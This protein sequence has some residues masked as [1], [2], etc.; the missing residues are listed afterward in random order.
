V[1]ATKKTGV[2]KNQNP[3]KGGNPRGEKW[4]KKRGGVPTPVVHTCEKGCIENRKGGKKGQP[5]GGGEKKDTK[6]DT[7]KKNAKVDK[8][9]Q[10][11]PSTPES[12]LPKAGGG[13]FEPRKKIGATGPLHARSRA[14][15][16][17]MGKTKGVGEGHRCVGGETT[18][19]KR[20]NDKGKRG[21]NSLYGYHHKLSHGK[22]SVGR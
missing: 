5:G 13:V 14:K 9:T 15:K 17:P 7:R 18:K 12:E 3:S 1:T 11:Q 2:Q 6:P 4:G 19:K 8:G 20:G 10:T 16:K 22:K 21:V